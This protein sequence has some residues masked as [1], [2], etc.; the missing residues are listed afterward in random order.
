MT[1][2][3][4]ISIL[5]AMAIAL[6]MSGCGETSDDGGSTAESTAATATQTDEVEVQAGDSSTEQ[7][8]EKPLVDP[9]RKT[10][11]R[12]L[13]WGDSIEIVKSIEGE[14]I[15]GDDEGLDYEVEL[16]GIKS[17]ML[18]SFDKD[19]LYDAFYTFD[20]KGGTQ[21][22]VMYSRYCTITD[23]LTEKYGAPKHEELEL[24]DLIKYCD[25]KYEAI[26]LGYLSIYDTWTNTDGSNISA[27]ILRH[28]YNISIFVDFT[29]ENYVEPEK[30][31]GF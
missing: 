17:D 25:T 12:D 16:C 13:C 5:C 21:A 1:I 30:D 26:E 15:S 3:K 18:L 6:A 29:D 27:G 7:A 9:D 20:D 23:K 2:S 11:V 19:G 8:E 14:P 28:N 31:A 4:K 22:S 24:N 10:N